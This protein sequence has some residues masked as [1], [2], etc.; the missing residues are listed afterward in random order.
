MIEGEYTPDAV[1]AAPKMV[2]APSVARVDVILI[3]CLSCKDSIELF[4]Y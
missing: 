4:S 2:P 3:V 1:S